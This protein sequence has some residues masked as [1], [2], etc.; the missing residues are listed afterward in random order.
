[1]RGIISSDTV[2]G[3][4]MGADEN[5]A[6]YRRWLDEIW[7]AGNYA[8]AHELLA[9]DLVDH[10]TVPGQPAT[11]ADDQ[12]AGQAQR[13]PVPQGAEPGVIVRLR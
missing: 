6:M 3:G 12:A 2:S 10:N 5:K 7:G 11:G 13:P 4:G 9:E 1:L 8:V